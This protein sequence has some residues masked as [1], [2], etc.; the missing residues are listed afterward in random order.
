MLYIKKII[1]SLFITTLL[2]GLVSPVFA[3][4]PDDIISTEDPQ[5]LLHCPKRYNSPAAAYKP[6]HGGYP[7]TPIFKELQFEDLNPRDNQS[8]ALLADKLG[9]YPKD[10]FSMLYYPSTMGREIVGSFLLKPLQQQDLDAY[11]QMFSYDPTMDNL[12][13]MQYYTNGQPKDKGATAELLKTRVGRMQESEG[14]PAGLYFTIY[15]PID[16]MIAGQI[17]IG[18]FTSPPPEVAYIVLKECSGHGYATNALMMVTKI[19][20][21]YYPEVQN[22][23]ATVHPGNAPSIKVLEHV[24][25]VT[26]RMCTVTP[27]GERLNYTFPLFH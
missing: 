26:D 16:G 27:I 22:I 4:S 21:K 20:K 25:F 5:G 12:K 10:L 7:D 13:Y 1:A 18:A 17:A 6:I 9:T 15:R 2:F 8:I 24:G 23:V 3:G 19:V 11:G 14:R